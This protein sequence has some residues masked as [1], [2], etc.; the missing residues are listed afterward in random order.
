MGRLP[1]AT[2]QK[3]EGRSGG[4]CIQTPARHSA[5]WLGDWNCPES[6]RVWMQPG[7]APGGMVRGTS[8][9]HFL[10][11]RDELQAQPDDAGDLCWVQ[12]AAFN[13]FQP[14]DPRGRL[15]LAPSSAS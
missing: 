8:A 5:Q 4:S 1:K 2:Q 11:A 13:P 14:S 7:A 12:Q 10:A 15:E 6:K 9:E 3:E